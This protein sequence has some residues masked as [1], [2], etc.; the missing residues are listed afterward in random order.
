MLEF[1]TDTNLLRPENIPTHVVY[2]TSIHWE[3]RGDL[4]STWLPTGDTDKNINKGLVSP[5]LEPRL[6][7]AN[8][9]FVFRSAGA[10]KPFV[11][12][13]NK[14]ASSTG[15]KLVNDNKVSANGQ[16]TDK[17]FHWKI[18]VYRG[19]HPTHPHLHAKVVNP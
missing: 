14:K 3:V 11:G 8:D 17:A 19:M 16:V 18:H 9:F 1:P 15:E 6:T 13:T 7:D 10:E 12:I 5:I 4:E 2:P